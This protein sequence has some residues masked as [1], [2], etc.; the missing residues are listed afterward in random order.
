M[1]AEFSKNEGYPTDYGHLDLNLG[2]HAREKVYPK[3]YEWLI[4]RSETRDLY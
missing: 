2:M 4:K 3:I 1:G